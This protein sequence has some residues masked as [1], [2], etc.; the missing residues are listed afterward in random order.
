M[1]IT[2]KSKS[3]VVAPLCPSTPQQPI[4]WLVGRQLYHARLFGL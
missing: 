4:P 3:W 2:E 1:H